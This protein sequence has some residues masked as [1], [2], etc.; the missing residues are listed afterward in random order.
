MLKANFLK[1][2]KLLLKLG[3]I[4]TLATLFWWLN[5]YKILP[6]NLLL[7]IIVCV[8]VL[9]VG[10][11]LHATYRK[12]METVK[13]NIAFHHFLLFILANMI[14]AICSFAADFWNSY[15]I[16]PQSFVGISA[17]FNTYETIFEFVYF[18]TLTF[19]FFGYGEIMPQI[20]AT[21]L[22]VMMEVS[23]AFLNMIFVLADFVGLKESLKKEL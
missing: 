10:Y 21:K 22:L 6:N 4:S 3:F 9:K 19:S 14:L 11:L 2:V 17:N 20:V 23:L 18:S 7:S 5:T 12:I 13:K 15:S 1:L 16:N 8:A